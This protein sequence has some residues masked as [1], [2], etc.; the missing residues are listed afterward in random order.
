M[1]VPLDP[2][3]DQRQTLSVAGSAFAG[4]G[5]SWQSQ[6]KT[7]DCLLSTVTHAPMR[8]TDCNDSLELL[9]LAFEV[10][11]SRLAIAGFKAGCFRWLGGPALD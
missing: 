3:E 8:I 4:L 2:I 9:W 1:E 10:L 5:V 11:S 7:A 6:I